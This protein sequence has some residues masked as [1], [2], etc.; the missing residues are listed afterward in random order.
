MCLTGLLCY[1]VLE[2]SG[3]LLVYIVIGPQ[4][5]LLH[6]LAFSL[7]SFAAEQLPA[8]VCVE[9]A[10]LYAHV[11]HIISLGLQNLYSYTAETDQH[12]RH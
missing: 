12:T 7:A 3:C 11:L 2:S 5:L 10:L 4:F 1:V 8:F 6:G 9:I